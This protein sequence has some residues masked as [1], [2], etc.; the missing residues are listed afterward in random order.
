[1]Q[2]RVGSGEGGGRLRS[3]LFADHMQV[4]RSSHIAFISITVGVMVSRGAVKCLSF[5]A[6]GMVMSNESELETIPVDHSSRNS[7]SGVYYT[8]ALMDFGAE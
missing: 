8:P 7:K 6:L 1:M 2:P 5:R 4:V 3:D